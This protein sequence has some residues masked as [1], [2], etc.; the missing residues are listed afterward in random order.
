[1][2]AITETRA[3]FTG[4]DIELLDAYW[5]AAN[6]LSAGQIYL[7]D[8]PLLLMPCHNSWRPCGRSATRPVVLTVLGSRLV[9]GRARSRRPSGHADGAGGTGDRRCR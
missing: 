2:T 4:T 3:V 6:Y 8:N 9:T 5:R 1:M 7:L